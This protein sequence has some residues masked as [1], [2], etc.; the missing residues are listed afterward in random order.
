MIPSFTRVNRYIFDPK[1]WSW[2]IPSGTTCPGA[3]QCLSRVHRVT[4][5]MWNGPEQ[6]FRCYSAVTERYPSVRARYWCNFDAVRGKTPDEVATVLE[7]LPRSARMVR[8]HTAGDFFSQDYFDGWLLFIRSRPS[9]RFW[10]FTKSIPFWLA[11][12][13]DIPENLELQASRG[14][15]YD[16]L[17][18]QHQLKSATVVFSTGE[19]E[20]LGLPI[21]TDDRLAAFPGPS[22]ALLENFTVR[23]AQDRPQRAMPPDP[24]S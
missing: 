22:F 21:D 9:V 11:R 2:S 10:A 7:C 12:R 6:Q 14:G 13:R 17:I 8:I 4:G 1:A 18:E 3:V 20:R 19:A 23:S 16:E 24:L 15:R 5:E